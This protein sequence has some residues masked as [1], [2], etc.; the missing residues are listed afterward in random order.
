MFVAK[1]EWLLHAACAAPGRLSP[2]LFGIIDPQCDVAHTVAV[3]ANVLRDFVVRAQWG[4]Q[5]KANL[6]LLQDVGS[7]VTLA[8]LGARVRY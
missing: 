3:K 4:G 5:Y 1:F 8:G 7:T 2:C 6:A